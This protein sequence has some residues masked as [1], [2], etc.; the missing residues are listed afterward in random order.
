MAGP[1][2]TQRSSSPA[3]A[4]RRRQAAGAARPQG[5][6]PGD[7][8]ARDGRSAVLAVDRLAESLERVLAAVVDG[9]LPGAAS[10]TPRASTSPRPSSK[11][12]TRRTMRRRRW[13]MSSKR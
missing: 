6:H 4:A 11:G 1:L 10:R 9:R 5:P 8:D 13:R 12:W 3:A 2:R 7:R